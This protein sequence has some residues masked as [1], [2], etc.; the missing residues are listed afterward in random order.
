MGKRFRSTIITDPLFRKKRDTGRVKNRMR[1]TPKDCF[2]LVYAAFCLDLYS[3]ARG[4]EN[5][6]AEDVYIE[7]GG[8]RVV[9][10]FEVGREAERL[11]CLD[12]T[13][14]LAVCS[15]VDVISSAYLFGKPFDHVPVVVI[16]EFIAVTPDLEEPR[17]IRP[18][19]VSLLC[20]EFLEKT[21][22]LGVIV[23]AGGI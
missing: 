8:C 21:E 11:E 5:V 14:D 23:M 9:Y 18:E 3:F 1:H 6:L 22:E 10:V 15:I 2:A 7:V 19:G 4:N 12:V 20:E 16:V 17:S 13:V